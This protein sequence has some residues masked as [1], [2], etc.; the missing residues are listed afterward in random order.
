LPD[1]PIP[2]IGTRGPGSSEHGSSG[3]QL[4]A[5]AYGP[6]VPISGM[7]WSGKDFYNPDRAGAIQARRLAKAV[8]LTGAAKACTATLAFFPGQPAG[9]VLSLIDQSGRSLDVQRWSSLID[10]S[11]AGVGDRYT[12]RANLVEVATQ[13]HFTS[14]ERIW[15]RLSLDG[16]MGRM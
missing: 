9:R 2:L 13:G 4:L 3:A 15:E 1:H 8:V 11:L 10:L 12:N 16:G 5:D 6:R 7:G 14:P